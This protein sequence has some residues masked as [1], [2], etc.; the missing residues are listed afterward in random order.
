[1]AKTIS[2]DDKMGLL[3]SLAD[4]YEA[5]SR[6]GDVASNEGWQAEANLLRHWGDKLDDSMDDLRAAIL[7]D[8][9]GKATDL[10]KSIDDDAGSISASIDDLKDDA[11]NAATAIK[12]AGYV[13]DAIKIA[14]KVLA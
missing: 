6:A 14:A 12:I 11:K 3:R 7:Q 5:V 4:V 9:A 8:W 13:D 10:T 2:G 1:M